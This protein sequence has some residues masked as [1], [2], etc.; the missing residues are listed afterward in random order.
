MA[1]TRG[2]SAFALTVGGPTGQ[3]VSP[4]HFIRH[5]SAERRFSPRLPIPRRER[6]REKG[7]GRQQNSRGMNASPVGPLQ[8]AQWIDALADVAARM[9]HR[10]LRLWTKSLATTQPASWPLTRT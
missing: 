10:V 4:G 9:L 3:M 7:E 8:R 1:L 2:R 5:G 6:S